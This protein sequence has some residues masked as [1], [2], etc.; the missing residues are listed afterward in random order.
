MLTKGKRLLNAVKK[1]YK[2][3]T[4]KDSKSNDVTTVVEGIADNY[5]GEGGSDSTIHYY[6]L[7]Y[8]SSSISIDLKLI[9]DRS[10]ALNDLTTYDLRKYL[11]SIDYE[12]KNSD[13]TLIGFGFYTD[14]ENL[15]IK[16]I[17]DGSDSLSLN[18]DTISLATIKTDYKLSEL[19]LNV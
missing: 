15:Y 4:G 8:S 5:T 18:E 14:D 19:K 12:R 9:S 10:L 16:V 13:N 1:I 3:I 11:V 7:Y 2:T 17:N 6:A